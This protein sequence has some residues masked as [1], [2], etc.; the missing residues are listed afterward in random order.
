MAETVETC[1]YLVVDDGKS[2]PLVRRG[3]VA[4]RKRIRFTEQ[5][6]RNVAD[7]VC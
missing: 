5:L 4:F 1:E 2:G 7:D 3:L 6:F